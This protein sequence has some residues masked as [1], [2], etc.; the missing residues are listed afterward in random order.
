[1]TTKPSDEAISAWVNLVRAQTFLLDAIEADLKRAGLPPLSWYDLLLELNRAAD[2][3]LRPQEIEKQLLLP[4]HGVSRLI[5]RLEKQGLA[6]R[7]ALP[8]D[9]RA[10]TVAITD[11]GR[12]MLKRMWPV[13]GAAIRRL[14]DGKLGVQEAGQLAGLLSRLRSGG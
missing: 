8:D 2:G 4:Q 13:Y 9:K 14:V 7:R 5:D 1:M 6:A 12:A 10:Q 11:E 3:A